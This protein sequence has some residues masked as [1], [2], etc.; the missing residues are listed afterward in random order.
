[1]S[2]PKVPGVPVATRRQDWRS[3]LLQEW[4]LMVLALVL[5]VLLW[6]AVRDTVETT[7]IL[8]NVQVQ[9]ITPRGYWAYVEEP[10]TLT[11][12]GTT[13]DVEDA[14][15]ALADRGNVIGLEVDDLT[16]GTSQS[17]LEFARYRYRFAAFPARL[18]VTPLPVPKGAIFRLAERTVTV[19]DPAV[20]IPP[21]HKGVVGHVDSV[22]PRRFGVLAPERAL[23]DAI[24]P[25]PI[26][27]KA[28]LEKNTSLT[29]PE[30]FAL[31]FE[32]WKE[33]ERANGSAGVVLPRITATVTF[34]VM[35]TREIENKLLKDVPPDVT[36]KLRSTDDRLGEERYK[37]EIRASEARLAALE[38]AKDQWSYVL[39]ILPPEAPIPPGKTVEGQA[40]IDWVP[41]NEKLIEAAAKKLIQ[42]P[43]QTLRVD[44]TAR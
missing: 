31:T 8:Q 26:D 1:V 17:A 16:E 2:G 38:A 24:E 29:V 12:K 14:V 23:D 37:G 32:R 18:V 20:L 30:T 22:E 4:G 41:K 33:K 5:A 27:A 13:G 25:D 44:L 40:T 28:F 36:F 15:K 10:I 3:L 11:F 6:V 39:T 42:F 21:D 35:T 7:Q 9:P 43:R 19:Q 34:R